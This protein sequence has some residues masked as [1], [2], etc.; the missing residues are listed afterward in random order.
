MRGAAEGKLAYCG[1]AFY[2]TATVQFVICV[3][4]AAS[5]YGPPAYSPVTTTISDLQA[6]GCGA[7]QGA[8]V[9]SPL[10]ILANL[11]VAA[12][13]LLI[14]GG[15]LLTRS[16][17]PGTGRRDVAV[18]L[19]VVAGMATFANAFTPEDV[20]FTGDLVTALIAFLGANFGL[21][22]MGRA[23]AG[24]PGW[25][26]YSAFTEALGTVGAAAIILDGFGAA[27]L[28]GDGGIEWL[29]IAPILVWTLATGARLIAWP[30]RHLPHTLAPDD[31]QQES[32][33]DGTSV[34][35]AWP[36]W[37]FTGGGDGADKP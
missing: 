21:I 1:A 18:G 11:S 36:A 8:N 20:T 4:L 14:A 25:G 10:N 33:A 37:R 27:A 2:I 13:G 7:F 23:M 12:L 6:V 32:T 29:I 22:Q 16:A 17:F 15:S 9:C 19:L 35:T 26:R 3:A 24:D 31:S 5:R 34:G 30:R 28:L